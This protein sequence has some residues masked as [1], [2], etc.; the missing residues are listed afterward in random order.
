MNRST[1]NLNCCQFCTNKEADKRKILCESKAQAMFGE[2]G[3]GVRGTQ[4]KYSSTQ[5]CND[6][7]IVKT[8][9][10]CMAHQLQT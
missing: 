4:Q 2:V 1:L 7:R 10:F 9:P 6:T 3:R 8:H 5:P